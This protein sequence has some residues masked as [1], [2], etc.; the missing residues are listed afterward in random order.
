MLAKTSFQS[1]NTSPVSRFESRLCIHHSYKYVYMYM[2]TIINWFQIHYPNC[3]LCVTLVCVN[4]QINILQCTEHR[5]APHN[6]RIMHRS[7]HCDRKEN[8][9]IYMTTIFAHRGHRSNASHLFINNMSSTNPYRPLIRQ[10]RLQDA[11]KSYI[12]FTTNS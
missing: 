4:K 1:P 8:I 9:Y 2:Y 3:E 6:E 11:S 5:D 7:R 10:Q 12:Y